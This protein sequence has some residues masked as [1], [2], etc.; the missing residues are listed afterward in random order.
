MQPTARRSVVT[1]ELLR[2]PLL[3]KVDE[4]EL[5]YHR[6]MTEQQAQALLQS[7]GI[8]GEPSEA[9]VDAVEGTFLV[10]LFGLAPELKEVLADVAGQ[11]EAEAATSP[12]TGEFSATRFMSSVETAHE[13]ANV[14]YSQGMPV[15]FIAFRDVNGFT[16]AGAEWLAT[17]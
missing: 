7:H 14:L 6:T 4:L 12:R 10:A 11:V 16:V 5:P 17:D 13:Q 1:T 9:L 15:W 3:E 2:E 8:T